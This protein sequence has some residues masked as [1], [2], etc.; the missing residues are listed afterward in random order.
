MTDSS[1]VTVFEARRIET[2]D[3][4][5]PTATHVAVRDGR[6]LAVGSLSDVSS[7][8]AYVLDRRF[9]DNVLLPGFVEGHAH[10]MEGVQW[11][12]TYCG[13][14]DRT[15]PDG[16][17]WQGLGSLDALVE[18]LRAVLESSSDDGEPIIGFGFDPIYFSG[19][20]CERRHLDLVSTTRPVVVM[21]AS[22]HITNVNTFA[23]ERLGWMRADM[24]LP[25][26]LFG[27]DGL[28]NGELR[29]PMAQGPAMVLAKIDMTG[30]GISA[31]AV[32]AYGRL[33]A[34]VGVTT[35]TDL[36]ARLLGPVVDM[37][38]DA[39]DDPELPFR[40]VPTLMANGLSTD[41]LPQ[42]VEE[43]RGRSSDKL[44]LGRVKVIADGSIQGF[45]AR[46]RWPG[47]FNGAPQGLWYIEPEKLRRIYE[48]G[49]E[50]GFQ[51]HTHTNGDEAIELAI[52]SMDAACA[53]YKWPDHRFVLQHCQLADR[54]QLRRMKSLG[55]CANFFANHHFYWGDQHRS[56]T[57]GP[58]RAERMNPCRS[59]VEIG[60]PFSI[61]SDAPVTPLRP[62]HVAW[63]AVNRETA[64]GATLGEF[65][66]ITVPEALHAVT[67]GA[68]Y[69]LHLD[70]EIGSIECGKRADFAVLA[71]DPLLVPARDLRDIEVFG[72]VF[73]GV[74]TPS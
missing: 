22:G 48:L 60:V 10:L 59:A 74:A 16:R 32:R 51:V 12:W 11:Q 15:D 54:A 1:L 14:F 42:M 65:E 58:D 66:R 3:P 39:T 52:E 46:L 29:G 68:A 9:A 20:R 69:T 33:A 23:L 13:F 71:E 17:V 36:A 18:R 43:L 24:D 6:I 35:S 67:L 34:R 19:S 72:T 31:S 64:S 55:M 27:D 62:L 8:G 4:R 63:C 56:T 38:R 30:S 40:L 44:R 28:A 21:H 47:Y 49:L 50:H 61:H 41:E 57:V 37:L 7:W 26:A 73:G 5:R 70:G 2:M 25:G 45:S 53:G